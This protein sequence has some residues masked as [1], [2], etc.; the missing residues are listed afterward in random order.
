MKKKYDNYEKIMDEI[1]K[2]DK[3]NMTD[4]N[5][6]KIMINV[7]VDKPD[8]KYE[9]KRVGYDA[10]NYKYIDRIETNGNIQ[11]E[12][13][14]FC[15]ISDSDYVVIETY[16]GKELRKVSMILSYEAF[17][18]LSSVLLKKGDYEIF[19]KLVS[20]DE[21]FKGT[22]EDF[23]V[24]DSNSSFAIC[25]SVFDNVNEKEKVNVREFDH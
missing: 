19:S 23:S 15:C 16:E 3:I 17:G 1:E 11:E 20:K 12:D 6:E 22:L 14:S 7:Y 24:S 18:F 2:I 13:C 21:F 8:G 5:E 10:T 4:E 9:Y 25:P